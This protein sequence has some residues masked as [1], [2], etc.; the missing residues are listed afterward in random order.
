M[1]ATKRTQEVTFE[2]HD[3]YV[4]D[5]YNGNQNSSA[6]AIGDIECER[7][8][9]AVTLR[10]PMTTWT[11]GLFQV[12]SMNEGASPIVSIASGQS[13]VVVRN[14]SKSRISRA[15]YL[16]SSGISDLF[17]LP[18]GAEKEVS[19]SAPSQPSP[20]IGWYLSQLDQASDEAELFQELGAL[21]DREIGGDRAFVQ[22]FFGI[23]L[24]PEV[25]NR[26]ERP[27]LI[28]FVDDGSDGIG[29]QG[30]LKRR[31]KALYV[32]HL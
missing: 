3:T 5:V 32:V 9:K 13:S 22:G 2:G 20:F 28:G 1:P 24:L 15:V 11:S 19:I 10:V 25:F 4:N 29:F 30:S 26:L 18:A 17:D 27:L 23:Q 14:L 16:D 12:R 21:L 8:P 6:S 31:S 7:G